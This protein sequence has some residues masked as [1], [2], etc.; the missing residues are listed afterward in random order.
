[1]PGLAAIKRGR[2]RRRWATSGSGPSIFA[3][4]RDRAIAER[5]AAAM[6]AAVQRETRVVADLR[7]VDFHC[8]ARTS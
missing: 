4:C 8:A 1:V 7:L 5:V 3:L 2:R 6:T